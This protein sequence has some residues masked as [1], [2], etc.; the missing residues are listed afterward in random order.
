MLLFEALSAVMDPTFRVDEYEF[1]W[2]EMSATYT[3][4]DPHLAN[5][6]KE[7]PPEVLT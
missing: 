7:N 2:G 4:Q 6:L 5:Y 1:L 3:V